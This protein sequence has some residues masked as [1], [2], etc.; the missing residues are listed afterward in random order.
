[1]LRLTEEQSRQFA[2]AVAEA[3]EAGR[4]EI[5]AIYADFERDRAIVRPRCDA[6]GRCCRFE[7]YGHRLF[8]TTIE[9]AAFARS[10]AVQ[11]DPTWDGTGCPYQLA[12]RCDAH[13][14]RPF[15]CRV[16]F[17]DESTTD[18]QQAQYERMHERLRSLHERHGVPYLY[19]E[20]RE[21]LKACGLATPLANGRSL[22][23]L[24]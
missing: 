12:G 24:K 5:A 3:G 13:A 6:S 23:V 18:W 2:R 17:C 10:V 16:Y 9:M 21:A 19:V 8:I 11:S 15:G 22:R 7:S 20:W 1:V 14:A 4:Q